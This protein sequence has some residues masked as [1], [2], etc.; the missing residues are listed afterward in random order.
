MKIHCLQ[1]KTITE[2]LSLNSEIFTFDLK[3]QETLKKDIYT[4]KLN[5]LP[6][7]QLNLSRLKRDEDVLN[8]ELCFIRQQ[9]EAAKIR[10][11]S[12]GGRFRLSIKLAS[13]KNQ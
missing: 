4:N 3:R 7:K 9:L 2:L 11:A 13:L 12:E 10:A 6:E 1:G 8:T 5:Q